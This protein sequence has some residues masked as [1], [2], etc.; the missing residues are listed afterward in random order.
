MARERTLRLRGVELLR[1]ADPT[2]ARAALDA[3][4]GIRLFDGRSAAWSVLRRGLWGVGLVVAF[5]ARSQRPWPS[6]P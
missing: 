3:V 5:P 2:D 6:S 4:H 1:V